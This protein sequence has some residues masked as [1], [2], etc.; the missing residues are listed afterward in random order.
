MSQ[1]RIVIVGGGT[2][3]ITVAAQLRR[4]SRAVEITLVEPSE[5]HYYQPLWT[6]V[7]AG[8]FPKEKSR[9]SEAHY[10]P[11]GVRWVRDYC[12]SIEPEHRRLQT[13]TGQTIDYDFLVMCPGLKLKWDAIKGLA[14]NVGQH[15]ICSNYSFD[16]VDTTWEQIRN[17]RGGTAL[18]THPLGAVKCGGAPQKICY[19]A[20]DYFRQQGIRDKC[21]LIFA[22]A[23]PRI[24]T[25]DKY[26]QALEKVVERKQI[27]THFKYDLIEIRPEARQAVFQILETD[28]TETFSYDMIHVTPKMGP[29]DFLA[30]SPLA[31]AAGWCDVNKQ[32][33]QHV[34]HPAVFALGDASNLPTSKTGAAVRKQ[35][36]V[37]VANLLSALNGQPLSATYNGYT[38]CPL[39][40]GYRSMILAEFDYDLQPQETFPF[41][42]GRE[43]YSMLLLKK[44]GLPYLYWN[45]MLRGRG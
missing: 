4:K 33:L 32:T 20:E 38:S 29:P 7:G 6:L 8:I 26:A 37:L 18:F 2:A 30:K 39:V 23:W 15:G 17:F 19:L 3:G 31:D 10:I 13:R 34:K 24:F 25:A 5:H 21:K 44:Y 12:E 14:G 40:T 35:A 11:A 43:R 36:P 1:K 41:D 16:T 9:R 22:A 42:Q 45:G 27:E 28:R